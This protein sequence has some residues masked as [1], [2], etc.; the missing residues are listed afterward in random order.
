MVHFSNIFLNE[1]TPEVRVPLFSRSA[2][3]DPT[4]L[5]DTDQWITPKDNT[6]FDEICKEPPR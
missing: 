2:L 5:N 4:N 3:V 1:S 6:A